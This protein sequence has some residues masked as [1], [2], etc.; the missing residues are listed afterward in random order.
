MWVF[1]NM[2][3]VNNYFFIYIFL[4]NIIFYIKAIKYLLQNLKIQFK[5][6]FSLFKL[7]LLL[8]I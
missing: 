4:Y 7:L 8:N 2:S 1:L 3:K 6:L 5:I